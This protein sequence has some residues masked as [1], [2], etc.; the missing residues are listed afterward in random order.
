[1][2]KSALSAVAAVLALVVASAMA[3][4][5]APGPSVT[6]FAAASLKNALDVAAEAYKAASGVEIKISY[7]AS[8]TLARQIEAGAPAD[9][10]ISA[11]AA[12][13]DYL[14]DRKLIKAETRADLLGNS[15]V[16]VAPKSSPLETLAFTSAAFA[17][18]IGAESNCDRRPGVGSGRRL[19]ESGAGKTRSVARRSA[20]SR[21]YGQ[22]PRRARL[23]RARGSAARPRLR[24]RRPIGAEGENRRDFSREFASANRLSDR[25]DRRRG[26]AAARLLDFLKGPD[27]KAIFERHGFLFLAR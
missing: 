10:F 2:L 9:L 13:M 20:A 8:L 16:V 6:I 11:D 5:P 26:V 19:C 15:L 21:L 22:C 7:A 24:H 14:A 25:A 4:G 18:A 3:A 1:M 23:R 27:G 12:S 17:S